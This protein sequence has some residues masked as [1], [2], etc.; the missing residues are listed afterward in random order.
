MHAAIM[1]IAKVPNSRVM[2]LSCSATM[3]MYTPEQCVERLEMWCQWHEHWIYDTVP[4]VGLPNAMP[5]RCS[6]PPVLPKENGK[7]QEGRGRAPG[8]DESDVLF[9]NLSASAQSDQEGSLTEPSFANQAV[10]PVLGSDISD[11][12]SLSSLTESLPDE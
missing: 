1:E 5:I 8:V 11:T 2:C 3:S 4:T 9:D 10:S 6:I 12:A 7:R